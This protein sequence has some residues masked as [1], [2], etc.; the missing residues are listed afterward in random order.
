VTAKQK[1]LIREGREVTRR[2]A[3]KAQEE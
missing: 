3:K 1:T 2:N